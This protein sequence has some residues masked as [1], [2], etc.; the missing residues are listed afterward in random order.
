L[1]LYR[2]KRPGFQVTP[3]DPPFSQA[4]ETAAK[5]ALAAGCLLVVAAGN[6]ANDPRYVG[7][8]GTL[9]NSPSVLTV[10]AVDNSFATAAFSNRIEPNAPGVKGPDVAAPGVD[11]Y[12]SWPVADGQYNTISGTSMATPHVAG[13]AA[14]LAEANPSA[15]GQALKDLV[16]AQCMTLTGGAARQGEIGVGFVQAPSSAGSA[17]SVARSGGRGPRPGGRGRG[18]ATGTSSAE[19]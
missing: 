2:L 17:A 13:V 9:G 11:V 15:R 8:V 14:L 16:L 7:A 1:F 6:E 19:A 5:T 12:S 10:A 4:Y 3:G 18:R